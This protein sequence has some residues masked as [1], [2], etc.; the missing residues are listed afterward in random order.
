[1][2]RKSNF[3][4]LRII[5]MI[6][7]ILHHFVVHQPDSFINMNIM[8]SS[9]FI[10]S[11]FFSGGKFGV[12]L[13]IM[14]TGY[15]MIDKDFKFNKL[16]KLELQVL[17]Y[18]LSIFLLLLITGVT[19]FNFTELFTSIFPVINKK[20]WFITSY[21]KCYYYNYFYIYSWICFFINR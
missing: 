18:T 8:S 2:K 7:I 17:F 13:F 20:Y 1:M 19:E 11:L 10:Y 12:A 14:I 15:F 9:N 5:A 6:F 16:I 4:L 3:E 21:F